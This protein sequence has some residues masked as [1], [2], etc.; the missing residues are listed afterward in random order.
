MTSLTLI[1]VA[2]AIVSV[3]YA[4]PP[5]KIVGGAVASKGEIPYIVSLNK[6]G[7]HFCGG[8]IISNRHI[9]TAAHCVYSFTPSTQRSLTI[10]AGSSS[11]TSG[12]KTYT[13]DKIELH[14]EYIDQAGSPPNDIAIIR[15]KE[16]ITL[17]Q[18]TKKIDLVT[19]EP[20]ADASVVVSGWGLRSSRSRLTST[21][22][23]TVK[24]KVV[25]PS[26]CR[27]SHARVIKNTHVCAYGS[28]G[29]G[30]C[31]GDS[32]GPLALNGQLA[33]LVS[34]GLPCAIGH[35]DVYTSV[36]HYRDWISKSWLLL[37][38]VIGI[39]LFLFIMPARF[40]DM[41]NLCLFG[42]IVQATTAVTVANFRMRAKIVG[43]VDTNDAEYPFLVG[44]STED[45]FC[46]GSII[47]RRY[48]LT[49]AHCVADLKAS[50]L[51]HV[52][53]RTGNLR[54][55]TSG[56]NVYG[57][58]EIGIHKGFENN[59]N[60]PHDIAIIKVNTTIKF[61]RYTQPISLSES[62]PRVSNKVTVVG[63]GRIAPLNRTPPRKPQKVDEVVIS[64]KSC[65]KVHRPDPI[66]RT[67]ICVMGSRRFGIC[68]GD[69]GGPA[70]FNNALVGI[71]SF[72]GPS[73]ARGV[74]DVFTS[75]PY[76]LEWIDNTIREM[77]TFST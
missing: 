28:V 19:A 67:H 18:N 1:F 39:V 30:V 3:A 48:I 4:K 43:G 54:S 42:I 9:L 60:F 6:N 38:L 31:M 52:S 41:I 51:P 35:P 11:S 2:I 33:G 57:V 24:I 5:Q 70:L 74:P 32:G 15:V 63:W 45:G 56:G 12:G 50:D 47:S 53:V 25:S 66:D 49:A 76:H 69:S 40:L 7:R 36:Y 22:L 26:A 17:D 62:V 8:S 21:E 10:R 14:P 16:T 65:A 34:F 61:D 77:N 64:R 59:G 27:K 72:S 23:Y 73:C 68:A 46:S 13:V 71:T 29:H 58:E 55:R 37:S 44:I 75:I 20:K